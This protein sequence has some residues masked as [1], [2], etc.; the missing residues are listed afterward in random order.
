MIFTVIV[1]VVLQLGSL[2]LQLQGLAPIHP[3][4]V[5]SVAGLV[6]PIGLVMATCV[7]TAALLLH[8]PSVNSVPSYELAV[9]L[10]GDDSLRKRWGN[11]PTRLL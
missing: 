9:V 3:W 8:Q 10:H 11:V 1:I 4:A 5:L 2:Q 7:C 6:L